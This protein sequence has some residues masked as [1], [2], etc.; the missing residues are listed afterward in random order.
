MK[1]I[2]SRHRRLLVR[3]KLADLM[4]WLFLAAILLLLTWPF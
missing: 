1:R 2:R 3:R 4:M